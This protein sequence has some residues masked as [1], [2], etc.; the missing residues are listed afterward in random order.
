VRGLE[1]DVVGG[2]GGWRVRG[3]E[4]EEVGGC[5]GWRV[6]G[7]RLRGWCNGIVKMS[8]RGTQRGTFKTLQ[9]NRHIPYVD[10]TC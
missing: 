7:W 6:R 5:G 9:T 1:G 10:I 2:C 4:S 8:S 3:L